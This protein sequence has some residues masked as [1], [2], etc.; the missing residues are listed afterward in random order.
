MLRDEAEIRECVN[1]W[2]EAS[3]AGDLDTV[4]SLMTED[5]VFL[6]AGRPPMSKT[7][8]AALSRSA[9]GLL[10]P[11][12]ESHADIQEIQVSG[13]LAFMRC[14]LAV[15]VTPPGNPATP[16]FR[17]GPTLT[18]FKRVEGRWLLAR[19]ANFLMPV[20]SASKSSPTA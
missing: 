9:P 3:R 1:R 17:A 12:I 10:K 2:H 16:M 15:T 6:T 19:D 7:E 18:V 14:Q 5:A 11:T 13:D 8:F 20:G 4:L